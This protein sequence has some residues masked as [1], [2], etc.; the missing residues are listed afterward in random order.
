MRVF[1]ESRK[2]VLLRNCAVLPVCYPVW[3]LLASALSTK[4]NRAEQEAL[5]A[6]IDE[7]FLAQP[8]ANPDASQLRG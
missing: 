7:A 2:R 6:R 3:A 1:E 8:E 5:N 4:K